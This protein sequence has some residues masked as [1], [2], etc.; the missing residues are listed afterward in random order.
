MAFPH[1]DEII[2]IERKQGTL[3]LP[4]SLHQMS[5]IL[6]PRESNTLRISS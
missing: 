5:L 2:A 3:I 6:Q 1:H 4:A